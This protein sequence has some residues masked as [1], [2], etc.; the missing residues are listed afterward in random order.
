MG[1]D[2]FA[3]CDLICGVCTASGEDIGGGCTAIRG[4]SAVLL[5]GGLPLLRGL[6]S[7]ISQTSANDALGE[8][9]NSARDM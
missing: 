2:W 7:S 6:V 3:I 9:A 4:L 1:E 8:Y 5:F